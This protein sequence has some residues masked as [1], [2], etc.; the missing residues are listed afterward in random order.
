MCQ[1]T[2]KIHYCEDRNRIPNAIAICKHNVV[3]DKPD[4]ECESAKIRGKPCPKPPSFAPPERKENVAHCY[5]IGCC[6]RLI[7]VYM[8]DWAK[9]RRDN[10]QGG[11]DDRSRE[12]GKRAFTHFQ[13]HMYCC[14]DRPDRPTQETLS[15][16]KKE[17]DED[18]KLKHGRPVKGQ[19][20]PGWKW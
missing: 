10:C 18:Y 1:W 13:V 5:E 15:E 3:F 14:E 19:T 9:H 16:L 4:E 2:K 8:T 12:L 11:F 6:E 20:A 7:G 17:V